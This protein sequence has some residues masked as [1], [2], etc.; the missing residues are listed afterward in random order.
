MI[1][2]SRVGSWP[3]QDAKARF[4]E[5]VRRAQIEGPQ[6]V[7]VHGRDSV[8]VRSESEYRKMAGGR[9]GSLLVEL[10]AAS[11]L[12]DIQIEHESVRGPVGDIDL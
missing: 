12:G 7:T 2:P 8:V 11:P 6:Y 4:S 10:M 1:G 3:L 9:S 5:L